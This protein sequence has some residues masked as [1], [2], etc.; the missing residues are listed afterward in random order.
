VADVEKLVLEDH[1]ITA[2]FVGNTST[3]P[4]RGMLLA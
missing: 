4:A 3:L 2:A 1:T